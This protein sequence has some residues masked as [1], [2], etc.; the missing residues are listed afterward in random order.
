MNHLTRRIGRASNVPP[1]P[2]AP[3]PTVTRA[4]HEGPT[5]ASAQSRAPI[6]APHDG[7][8]VAAQDNDLVAALENINLVA[9][10]PREDVSRDV[11]MPPIVVKVKRGLKMVIRP[12]C[13]GPHATTPGPGT[14]IA[15]GPEMISPPGVA[16]GASGVAAPEARRREESI[17]RVSRFS[18]CQPF[19]PGAV[20]VSLCNNHDRTDHHVW[21]GAGQ[22]GPA[23]EVTVGEGVRAAAPTPPTGRGSGRGGHTSVP[24]Q[25]FGNTISL[26]DTGVYRRCSDRHP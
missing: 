7:L 19:N 16:G 26:G 2:K 4:R 15:R 21:T 20:Y 5:G 13:L 23:D 22:I 3:I 9:A 11:N 24:Y 12:A 18:V 8:L 10:D 25:L 1:P 6:T 14:R 17:R